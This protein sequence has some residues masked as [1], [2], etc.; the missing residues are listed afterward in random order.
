MV[1]HFSNISREIAPNNGQIF[2]SNQSPNS[3][4][5][6][7]QGKNRENNIVGVRNKLIVP[8]ATFNNTTSFITAARYGR[9]MPLFLL[10]CPRSRMGPHNIGSQ[11]YANGFTD[12]SRYVFHNRR[13]HRHFP[14][15]NRTRNNFQ[16]LNDYQLILSQKK[17]LNLFK[18]DN[19]ATLTTS[20]IETYDAH[21]ND[22]ENLD[23]SLHL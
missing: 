11:S 2:P 10:D 3:H 22:D 21:E 17:E 12:S 5:M 4:S 13:T 9:R 1:N 14:Y 16:I 20:K 8:H 7:S 19:N 23:L 18:D 6:T 15:L